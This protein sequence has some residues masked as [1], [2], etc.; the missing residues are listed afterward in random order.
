MRALILGGTFNPVHIGHLRLA[1]ETT[2]R[3]GCE[4]T[5][6]LPSFAPVH[7]SRA[8]LLS[9][10]LRVEL[11]EAAAAG[12]AAV[13]V[14]DAE[15]RHSGPPYSVVVL[16]RLCAES[17]IDAPCFAMGLEQFARLPSWYRGREL[18]HLVDVA[19]GVREDLDEA[20]F[21]RIRA[22]AW[23]DFVPVE[24]P[25]GVISAFREP[26]GEH[27]ISLMAIPRLDVTATMI[28]RRWRE[29]RSLAHLVPD[30]VLARLLDHRDEVDAAWNRETE[31]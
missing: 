16:P 3:L 2:E 14:S 25:S 6:F 20:A 10:E 4:R 7:R 8:H 1:I 13:S 12:V 19:V 30:P 11:I 27:R 15:R 24:A 9:F 31:A 17:G 29:R 18:P 5:L 23:P 26:D 21:Q 22:T 28:R